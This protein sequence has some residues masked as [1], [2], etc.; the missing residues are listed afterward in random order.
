M[1]KINCACGPPKKKKGSRRNLDGK[2][3]T[4]RR[5]VPRQ[6]GKP[7]GTRGEGTEEK[8]LTG[9][10]NLKERFAFSTAAKRGGPCTPL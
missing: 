9:R 7:P 1:G 10:E 3:R 8:D 5:L 2:E 4:G 6:R